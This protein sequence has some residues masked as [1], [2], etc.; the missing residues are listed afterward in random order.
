MDVPVLRLGADDLT[1][2]L[3][4]IEPVEFRTAGAIAPAAGADRLRSAD[5]LV[6]TGGIPSGD[7][8][9]LIEDPYT[10]G[11]CIVP[12]SSLCLCR[13]VKSVSV[14]ARSL[15]AGGEATVALLASHDIASFH[16][17]MLARHVPGVGEISVSSGNGRELEPFGPRVLE[18]V[19]RAGITLSVDVTVD[20]AVHGANLLI[21]TGPG[22]EDLANTHP[23]RGSLLVNVT[24][25]DLP[26]DVVD[27]VDQIYVDDFGLLERNRHRRFVDVH[28]RKR[29]Y[30][31][32]APLRQPEGWHHQRDTWHHLR[33][34]EADLGQLV[35]GRHPGRT[36]LDDLLLFEVLGVQELDVALAARI[37]RIAREHGLGDWI[38]LPKKNHDG[39]SAISPGE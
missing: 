7:E 24:G 30:G 25:V 18:L 33:C 3:G 6:D 28:L 20:E 37:H 15:L 26:D 9:V 17:V 8:L 29:T 21:T 36:H 22:H 19:H 27:R 31:R 38:R 32:L 10:T 39:R 23:P 5:E 16:L 4:E 34:V 14:A 1:R 13:V 35:S 11:W 2:V 12:R